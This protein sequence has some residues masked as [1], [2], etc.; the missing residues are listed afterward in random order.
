MVRSDAAEYSTWGRRYYRYDAFLSQQEALGALARNVSAKAL[1]VY[2]SP[3]FH[4]YGQLWAAIDTAQLVDESNVCEV[5]RV[6]GHSRYSYVD[7][8]S[9][10]CVHS[11]GT[12]IESTPFLQ[13]L[14][15]LETTEPAQSNLSFLEDTSEAVRSA[16]EELGPLYEVFTS[17]V[18]RLLKGVDV[19]LARSLARIH[20]FQFV[21]N[22]SLLLGYEA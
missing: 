15:A 21:C 9:V 16:A 7:P 11:D 5:Q 8:G 10:G 14:D 1:V 18:D 2:G 17:M 4:T 20:S 13:A 3:A 6:I 19:E 22:V 12:P